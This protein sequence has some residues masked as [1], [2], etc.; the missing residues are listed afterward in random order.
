MDNGKGVLDGGQPISDRSQR[1]LDRIKEVF[2]VSDLPGE[3]KILAASENGIQ[4][5]YMNL[6]R[7]LQDGTLARR[8]KLLVALGV[9]VS[10]GSRA[11]V[12]FLSEAA[13]AA[14]R[15]REEVLDTIGVAT[16]CSIFNGYYKFRGL[17]P[18]DWKPAFEA[19]KAPINANAFVKSILPRAEM[20]S[21][22][23]GVSVANGC[24]SC[25]S[26][27]IEDARQNGVTDEQ[28]DEIVRAAAAAFGASMALA[29]VSRG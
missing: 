6:N 27:H 15:S 12:D 24:K 2:A 19:F 16:T 7:Q 29:A 21:V 22:C 3:F 1:A 13:L 8:M 28:I 23:I 17:I 14:G 20:E 10:Q 25:V 26:G 5:I 9:A 4:D 18:D 11:A